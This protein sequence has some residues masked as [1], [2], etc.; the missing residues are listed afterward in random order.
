MAGYA[1][2]LNNA[3]LPL[4]FLLV[5]SSDH[6]TG[7]TG[8]TPT[9]TLA[10]NDG[11]NTFVAV[12]GVVSEIGNGEYQVAPSPSD[13][14]VIG[15]VNLHATASGCDPVD[16]QFLV[17][18][19]NPLLASPSITAN[20][21][22][23]TVRT[24]LT[25]LLR[26]IK[27]YGAG[28]V[29]SAEDLDDSFAVFKEL[30]DSFGAQSL[31]KYTE[32]RTEFDID[33]TKGTP[34]NPYTVGAGGDID[35]GRPQVD[36]LRRLSYINPDWSPSV[37]LEIDMFLLSQD[38]WNGTSMKTLTNAVPTFAYYEPSFPF[39]SLYFWMVPTT[40]GMTGVIYHR[41][42]IAVLGSIDDTVS[43][44]PGYAKAIR[45]L[46]VVELWPVFREGDPTPTLQRAAID[47]RS[48]LVA[49][50]LR[51]VDMAVPAPGW[52]DAYSDQM[53]P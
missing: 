42:S 6:I 35:I 43:W 39:G 7:A 16:L 48:D 27:V 18:N 14:D 41:E 29:P 38:G 36:D 21:E 26:R 24:F 19:Y 51:M 47:A 5:L 46:L 15:P 50:N 33:I 40:T 20:T 2:Q 23:V 32:T 8:K 31:M 30:L 49:M 13:A 22:T 12:S 25:R 17:V 53:L 1:V 34:S 52:Y 3:S 11:L 4:R 28:E 10:K 9:V 37:P 45:D 44:P